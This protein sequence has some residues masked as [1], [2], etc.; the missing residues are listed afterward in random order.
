[1]ELVLELGWLLF[2]L[3]RQMAGCCLPQYQ[4]F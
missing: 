2:L 4:G 1:M 3:L